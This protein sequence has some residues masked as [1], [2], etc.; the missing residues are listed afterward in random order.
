ME[1]FLGDVIRVLREESTALITL[2]SV[3]TFFWGGSWSGIDLDFYQFHIHDWIDEEHPHSRSPEEYGITDKPVVMGEF[4]NTGLSS[5]SYSTLLESWY[6][7]G[8]AGAL[9]WSLTDFDWDAARVHILD[10]AERN[11]CETSY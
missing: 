11:A 5:A 9:S 1:T 3:A 10:F 6:A 7:N 4:P 8:Y 2:G